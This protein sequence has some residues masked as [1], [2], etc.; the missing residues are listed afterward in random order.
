MKF[1]ISTFTHQDSLEEALQHAKSSAPVVFPGTSQASA[2]EELDT[3]PRPI[4]EKGLRK[5][6]KKGGFPEAWWRGQHW[7]PMCDF[8][9]KPLDPL[10]VVSEVYGYEDSYGDERA[11]D[12]MICSVCIGELAAEVLKHE[13]A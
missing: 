7:R 6:L 12:V 10:I 5:A 3:I 2:L 13:Q 9:E 11:H 8:C 4:H 1:K